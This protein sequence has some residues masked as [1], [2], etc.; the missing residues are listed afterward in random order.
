MFSPT[1]IFA[2]LPIYTHFPQQIWYRLVHSGSMCMLLIQKVQTIA[3]YI[4]AFCT[5]LA[6]TSTP[7][8]VRFG[9]WDFAS[10][11]HF[12]FCFEHR[13]PSRFPLASSSASFSSTCAPGGE[14]PFVI[15]LFLRGRCFK[16]RPG[17]KFGTGE[18]FP[19]WPFFWKLPSPKTTANR[20][21]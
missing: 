9:W 21:Q 15:T 1:T 10:V 18:N 6:V 13:K 20:G 7:R 5:T 3:L 8:S 2:F 19:W 17:L 11:R 12:P 16:N 4:F 14:N